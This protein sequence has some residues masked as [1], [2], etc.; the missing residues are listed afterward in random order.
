MRIGR[1][2]PAALAFAAPLLGAFPA[3]ADP[4]ATV[5]LRALDKVTARTTTLE[6]AIG[7]TV[8]FRTLEITPRACDKRPPEERPE[9]AAFL[10]IVEARPGRPPESVFRGWMFASSPGLSAMQHPVYD[11][12]VLDCI[13]ILERAPSQPEEPRPE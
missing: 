10:E 1:L 5:V 13:H 11:V 3:A 7:N 2:A 12:W 4:Y 6:A 9:A 8:H